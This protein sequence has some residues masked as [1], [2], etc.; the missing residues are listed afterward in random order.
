MASTLWDH[1]P[2]LA[3]L[4]LGTLW[5]AATGV[6]IALAVTNNVSCSPALGEARAVL[7]DKTVSKVLSLAV[8]YG[9]Q[10][11]LMSIETF[12]ALDALA[13]LIRKNGHETVKDL[14]TN[15]NGGGDAAKVVLS[16]DAGIVDNLWLA[17]RKRGIDQVSSEIE[18]MAGKTDS[19][20]SYWQ[21]LAW[22][23]AEQGE[24]Y[25]ELVLTREVAEIATHTRRQLPEIEREGLDDDDEDEDESFSGDCGDDDDDSSDDD[26]D[27]SGDDDGDDDAAPELA[28]VPPSE[29]AAASDD[30]Q[31]EVVQLPGAGPA[32]EGA[33]QADA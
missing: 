19:K 26:D 16:A 1:A 25:V 2:F 7:G 23:I 27:S 10:L 32:E 30:E 24:A 17:V 28:P 29:G 4:G 9:D 14:L 12:D 13:E 11:P 6:I 5:T 31:L 8:R 18:A 15:L 20:P 33:P 3:G 21:S 22:I